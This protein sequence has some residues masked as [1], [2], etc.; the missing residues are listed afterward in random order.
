MALQLRALAVCTGP[1]LISQHPF[2][3]SEVSVTLVLGDPMPSDLEAP[4]I[5]MLYIQTCRQNSYVHEIK[6][7][8]K[9]L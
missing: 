2:G 9:Y 4:G 3:N 7:N 6:I 5:H 1:R 8:L